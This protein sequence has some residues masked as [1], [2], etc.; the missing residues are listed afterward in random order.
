MR[1]SEES[2]YGQR[3]FQATSLAVV[4]AET[5]TSLAVVCA[6]TVSDTYDS[7]VCMAIPFSYALFGM[8]IRMPFFLLEKKRVT[9]DVLSRY[10]YI[11]VCIYMNIYA[12]VCIYMFSYILFGMLI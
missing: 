6:E 3:L 2:W 9:L 5:V 7:L 10:V 4:C 11:S 12:Y 1:R 8:S